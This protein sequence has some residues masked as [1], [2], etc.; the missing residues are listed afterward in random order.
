MI[1]FSM[2]TDPQ[3]SVNMLVGPCVYPD[4]HPQSSRESI[5]PR[6]SAEATVWKGFES[7]L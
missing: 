2:F 6:D 7:V 4:R 3:W 1:L 5:P